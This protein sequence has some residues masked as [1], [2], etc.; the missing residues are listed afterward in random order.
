MKTL[1]VA[2][3]TLCAIAIAVLGSA[4]TSASPRPA[5][6]RP[7]RSYAI[8][9][10]DGQGVLSQTEL[11]QVED[12]LVQFLLDQGYV[13]GNQTLL[14]DPAQADALFRIKIAWNSVRT[15]FAI[16][17][18]APSYND[19]P[20]TAGL[21]P[22]DATEVP[23]P[24]YTEETP[25]P[26]GDVPYDPWP[27]DEESGYA[28]G[29]YW[30]FMPFFYFGPYGGFEHHRRPWPPVVGRP[31]RDHRPPR[32]HRPP[33]DH[34]PPRWTHYG[35]DGP[36][37][38]SVGGSTPTLVS[39]HR[40]RPSSG[41]KGS[42]PQ[43]APILRGNGTVPN[44]SGMQHQDNPPTRPA[45]PGFGHLQ[46][47]DPGRRQLGPSRS[48]LP[49]TPSVAPV[50]YPHSPAAD[51]N[52][53]PDVSS[54]RQTAPVRT[55]PATAPLRS[56]VQPQKFSPSPSAP[57][58]QSVAPPRSDPPP[59]PEFS[60]S[61]SGHLAPS[62]QP[63]SQPAPAMQPPSHPAPAPQAA[64][65]VAPSVQPAS[66]SAPSPQPPPASAPARSSTSS[67]SGSGS[68]S[69]TRDH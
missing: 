43:A 16:V 8:V 4:C 36:S 22:V 28:Y 3:W 44:N 34:R 18:V 53:Q 6:V 62:P 61:P 40:N 37:W 63:P 55:Q 23:P 5:S 32:E 30:A 24:A 56:P 66:H 67:S 47:P 17:D 48:D 42:S 1:L 29:P 26:D 7:V 20:A 27:Y 9:A 58:R 41:H 2:T 25:P 54:P 31:P 15:S 38:H 60:P 21:P 51:R 68:T 59:R 57:V 19:A 11:N 14:D 33:S 13:R 46:T 35:F 45:N 39:S 65:G 69:K 52:P 10:M 12:S 64:P 49:V 50:P